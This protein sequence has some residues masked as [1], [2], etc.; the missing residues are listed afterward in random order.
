MWVKAVSNKTFS[1]FPNIVFGFAFSQQSEAKLNENFDKTFS[2]LLIILPN[3]YFSYTLSQHVNISFS[4]TFSWMS[5]VKLNYTFCSSAKLYANIIFSPWASVK[6]RKTF[7]P[8][9]NVFVNIT[10]KPWENTK[11]NHIFGNSFTKI[12]NPWVNFALPDVTEARAQ[13]ECRM[14]R[15]ALLC[16]P[17]ADVCEGG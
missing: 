13:D 4:K 14:R 1:L 5:N 10:F 12:F 6:P 2:P 16:T 15:I 7:S 11:L 17:G 3:V 9:I 8:G